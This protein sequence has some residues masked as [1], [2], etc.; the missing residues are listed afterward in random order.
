MK[1][2]PMIFE[3]IHIPYQP[4]KMNSPLDLIALTRSGVT[5]KFAM[6]LAAKFDFSPK[7]IAGIMHISE[8]TLHRYH[9]SEKLDSLTSGI[10]L[11][12]SDL[13]EKG[14]KIF[15]DTEKFKQWMKYQNPVFSNYKPIELLD[16]FTGFQLISDEL[17]RIEHGIFA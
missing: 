13:Y 2:Q 15:G 10:M 17:G 5:K 11:Q 4:F 6:N 8:R 7:E 9:D 14:T 12:L 16:T 1:K 3:E